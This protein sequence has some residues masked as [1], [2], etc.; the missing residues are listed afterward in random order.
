VEALQEGLGLIPVTAQIL[1]RR[2]IDSVCAA[3]SFLDPSLDELHSPFSFVQMEPAV[4][5]LLAAIERGERIVV[6]GDYDVDG[7]T[8]TVVLLLALRAIGADIDYLVP[9]RVDDGYGLK[10]R[11]VNRAHK[12]GAKVLIAVDCGTTDCVAAA[13]ARELGIDLIIVDHHEPGDEIPQAT[14]IL[15]PRLPDAG[16]PEHDMAAVGVAFKL[17][18]GVLERHPRGLRGTTLLKLV[19]LG[20]VAD[21]VPLTGENRVIAYH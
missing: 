1:V 16:Y 13:R 15:N 17:A 10:S 5:R 11:G 20:T 9:H 18:R 6:H 21:M 3:Q 8:G 7:I 12:K 14:A 2:G 4:E 19:A